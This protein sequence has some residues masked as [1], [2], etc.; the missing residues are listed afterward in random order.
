[1]AK[2]AEEDLEARARV[3]S[4]DEVG[5]LT[6][7]FNSMADRIRQLRRSD[8]GKLLVVQQTTGAAIDSLYDCGGSRILSGPTCSGISSG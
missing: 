1:M 7:G 3:N 8:P 6:A 2:V 4:H 5:I